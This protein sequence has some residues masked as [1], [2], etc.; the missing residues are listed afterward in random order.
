MDRIAATV[1]AELEVLKRTQRKEAA[2]A[3]FAL[4]ME[5]AGAEAQ[6]KKEV[7]RLDQQ[8]IAVQREVQEQRFEAETEIKKHQVALGEMDDAL[9]RRRVET[10]N[11]ADAMLAL[12]NHLPAVA[13]ALKVNELNITEDTVSQ[14]GRALAGL[15]KKDGK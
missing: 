9:A 4:Q 13:G 15:L 7:L 10:A 12:V 14:L 2:V 8:V 1:A 3:E 11:L 5:T 6:Q